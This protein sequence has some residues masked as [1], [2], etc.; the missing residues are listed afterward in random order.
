LLGVMTLA[1]GCSGGSAAVRTAAASSAPHA[2]PVST[3]LQQERAAMSPAVRAACSADNAWHPSLSAASRRAAEEILDGFERAGI[4]IAAEQRAAAVDIAR[5]RVF[6]WVVR[7]MLVGA[8]LH[9]AGM[10]ELP[11]VRTAGGA[12]LRVYRTAFTPTPDAPSSCVHALLSAGGVRHIVNLYAGPMTTSDLEHAERAAVE[13]A[14]GTYQ[15]ARD[16]AEAA[17]WREQV[18]DGDDPR[19]AMLAVARIVR[20]HVL[21][22]GGNAPRGH[23]QVHCG[24]GMH[25]TGMVMGVIERCL[26][27][28]S[29]EAVQARYK[30]HVGWRS[31]AEPG[32][33]EAANIEFIRTF[34]CA[35]VQPAR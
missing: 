15:N 24:G 11:S 1:P 29:M 21:R 8:R 17:H 6:W 3:A 19:Q 20:E 34:D 22:P 2:D 4:A 33:Y 5:K 12:P 27:G 14:G 25:R 35:L 23:V 18:R 10:V 30:A 31:E 32:G 9:N 13:S 28:A 7:T 16:D 26:A